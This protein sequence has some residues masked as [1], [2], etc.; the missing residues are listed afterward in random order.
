[1]SGSDV[2]VIIIAATVGALVKSVT[3]M[4]FP[5][6]AIPIMAVFIPT[7]TAVAVV[8]LPNVAQ[9]LLLALKFRSWRTTARRLPVF[10]TAGVFGAALGTVAIDVI[11]E[12]VL[13][14][15]LLVMVAGYL[16]S[17]VTHPAWE[18]GTEVERRATVPVGALAGLFQGAIGISGPIVGT[19]Y[20]GLR[21]HQDAFVFSITSVFLLTGSTQA[22][23]LGLQGRYTDRWGVIALVGLIVLATIP[24]GSRLR[25]RLPVETFQRIVLVLLAV[26][27]LSLVVD[28]ARSIG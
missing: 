17:A 20:H 23:V 7:E 1:M 6:V 19:W 24:I 12:R 8:A 9:N 13:Q 18:I 4:G 3:G 28:L 14:V 10:C 11:G 26:S 15:A 22:A 27:C 2:A 16:V 5:L 25:A 21:L